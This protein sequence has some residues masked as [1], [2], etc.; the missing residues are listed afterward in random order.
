MSVAL[1]HAADGQW[2]TAREG[3]GGALETLL[4]PVSRVGKAALRESKVSQR[5]GSER[6]GSSCS[7]GTENWWHT[8]LW[9]QRRKLRGWLAS[10]EGAAG[11]GGGTGGGRARSARSG[12]WCVIVMLPMGCCCVLVT[13]SKVFDESGPGRCGGHSRGGGGQPRT[14]SGFLAGGALLACGCPEDG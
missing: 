1:S 5:T 10:T 6:Q 9:G 8:W 4:G 3:G 11:M 13:G 12:T 2:D 7:G 14:G